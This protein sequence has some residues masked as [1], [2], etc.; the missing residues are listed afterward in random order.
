MVN[1]KQK[2][3]M[4]IIKKRLWKQARNRYRELSNKKKDI[5][6]EYGRNRYRNMA[7]YAKRYFIE[8]N[9]SLY[10]FFFSYIIK[11]SL[12]FGHSIIEKRTFHRF[13]CSIDTNK[14]TIKK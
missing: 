5:K 1:K 4:K 10:I 11:I 8:K 9:I 7:E 2:G 6:R 13:K 14:V 12:R 3:I